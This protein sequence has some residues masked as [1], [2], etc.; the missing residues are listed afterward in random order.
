MPHRVTLVDGAIELFETC[1]AA[2]L[3]I[4][5]G[6]SGKTMKQTVRAFED[7]T[8]TEKTLLTDTRRVYADTRRP[9]SVQTLGPRALGQILNDQTVAAG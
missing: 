3:E 1:L 9:T 5:I 6:T 8:R 2:G 4:A 7:G